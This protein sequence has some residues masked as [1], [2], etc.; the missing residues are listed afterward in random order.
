ML[1]LRP[2]VAGGGTE[3]FHRPCVHDVRQGDV[4][5][6]PRVNPDAEEGG[7]RVAPLEAHGPIRGAACDLVGGTAQYRDAGGAPTERVGA[8]GLRPRGGAR[9]RGLGS[10]RKT[11]AR[12][13]GDG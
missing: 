1:Q 9:G 11:A 7:G 4:R 12:R 6:P 8:V 5:N 3:H 13:G 2:Q 10:V